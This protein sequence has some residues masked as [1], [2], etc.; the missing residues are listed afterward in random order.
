M[1]E[2]IVGLKLTQN[3]D[4]HWLHFKD[5]KG[6]SAALNIEAKFPDDTSIV[7]CCIRQW[8][9]DQFQNI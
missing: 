7:N 5:S 8:V 4:G 6:R 9:I 1:K 2:K 3:E